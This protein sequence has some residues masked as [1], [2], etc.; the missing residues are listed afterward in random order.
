MTSFRFTKVWLELRDFRSYKLYFKSFSQKNPARWAF[1]A[2][3]KLS[4]GYLFSR[5]ARQIPICGCPRSTDLT[6]S[7]TPRSLE[8]HVT[9][10][11]SILRPHLTFSSNILHDR[12]VLYILNFMTIFDLKFRFWIFDLNRLNIWSKGQKS[13]NYHEINTEK[14]YYGDDVL[15][16]NVSNVFCAIG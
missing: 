3:G 7:S 12:L 2:F 13:K 11:P 16:G 5:F 1:E 9:S 8:P 4:L 14:I 6:V 10:A 15:S